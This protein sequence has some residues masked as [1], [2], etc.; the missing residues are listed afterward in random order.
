MGNEQGQAA[1][2]NPLKQKFACLHKELC[3]AGYGSALKT[4]T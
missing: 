2:P 3:T 4:K 1:R